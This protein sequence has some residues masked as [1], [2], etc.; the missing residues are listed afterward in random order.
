MRTWLVTGCS[1]GIGRG[2]AK[3]ALERGE[4]VVVTARNPQSVETLVKAYPKTAISVAL[5]VTNTES[6][7]NA[8]YIA[9]QRFGSIDVLVNNAG[10]GYRA[11]LEEGEVAAIEEVFQTNVFG[12]LALMK[13]VL[14]GMR[15]Q[16]Q[17]AIINVSSIA[18]VYANVGS[19]YYA[20]TKAALELLSDALYQEV[21]PL[22]IK[23]MIV[24]PGAFK[25]RFFDD[26]LRGTS[27]KI[28]DYAE[29]AGKTRKEALV[30]DGNQLGDPDKAG[31]VIVNTILGKTYPTRLVLGS[32]A[33]DFIRKKL[34][35][36]LQ[37]LEAW[38]G[39]SEQ[40][41]R[42]GIDIKFFA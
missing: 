31:R 3:A 16:K 4:Q 30:N 17:G 20:A 25:T 9:E 6:I 19:G 11:A 33:V 39:V 36:R 38:Q 7:H 18:A 14:P 37:E 41:N 15:T 23:V 1:S 32:D 28:A 26:S 21:T 42:E 2:I 34:Q 5:D 35:N 29:T 12:P 8:V 13:A 40:T 10:H 27:I 24:E 22:G